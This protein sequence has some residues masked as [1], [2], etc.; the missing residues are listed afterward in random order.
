MRLDK[1]VAVM[2]GIAIDLEARPY[3]SLL[4]KESNP[5][6]LSVSCGG[7]GR[8]I[9]ENL[10]RMGGM[11][12]LFFSAVGD[13]VYAQTAIQSLSSIGVRTEFV[14]KFPKENT[15]T[16]ISILDENGN[17]EVAVASMDI[18]DRITPKTI[19][20]SVSVFSKADFIVL[21]GNL[22]KE[23][24]EYSAE[25]FKNSRLFLDPVS[26]EKAK[27]ARGILHR[28]HTIKP[29]KAEAEILSGMKINSEEDL[30]KATDALLSM[31]VERVFI[32]LG[33]AGV[34]FKDKTGSGK[35]PAPKGLQPVSTTGAGDA[36]SAAIVR[37]TV[38]GRDMAR[39]AS[40]AVLAASITIAVKSAVNEGIGNFVD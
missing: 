9:A 13:D 2:G 11:D 16:Y 18:L 32:S 34:F 29:N 23:A 6:C 38:L 4:L 39:I 27:K 35:V 14:H 12:V 20:G 28:C 24:L 22:S 25:Q 26:L 36:M 33:E 5:G 15:A 7:V 37:S 31:G 17:M 8:N 40:D 3:H 30:E 1:V 10:K 21:D 19:E